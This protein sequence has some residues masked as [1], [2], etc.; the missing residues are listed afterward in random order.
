MSTSSA[1]G[2]GATAVPPAD[3]TSGGAPMEVVGGSAESPLSPEEQA[4][5]AAVTAHVSISRPVLTT[6]VSH[7]PN[8]RDDSEYESQSHCNADNALAFLLPLVVPYSPGAVV[9]ETLDTLVAA[10]NTPPPPHLVSG[11]IIQTTRATSSPILP[12]PLASGPRLPGTVP[13]GVSAAHVVPPTRPLPPALV[14]PH[15]S[16]LGL[17][18]YS[19]GLRC[20]SLPMESWSGGHSSRVRQKAIP[21]CS[22][23]RYLA[24]SVSRHARCVR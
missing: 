8:S 7:S 23:A 9:H 24:N 1:V 3:D 20:V 22:F 6:S 14:L 11:A 12:S 19:A 4:A 17:A 18:E 13:T 15:L 5:I 16:I 2:D 10:A 21:R